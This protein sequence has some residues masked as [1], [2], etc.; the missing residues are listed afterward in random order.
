M[1]YRFEIDEG[2][3]L[4]IKYHLDKLDS[5]ISTPITTINMATQLNI[6]EYKDAKAND[7]YETCNELSLIDSFEVDMYQVLNIS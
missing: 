3:K 4:K 1:N 5:S 6:D 7:L 2:T